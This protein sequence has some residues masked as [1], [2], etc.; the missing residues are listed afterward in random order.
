MARGQAERLMPMIEAVLADRGALFEEL[1]A[2]GVGI[3]PGNFTGLRISVA[4][5]RG[6][7]LSLGV[8]AIGVSGFDLVLGGDAAE[9]T[10]P[11]LV[12]IPV[13]R[14]EHMAYV[15]LYLGLE[16]RGQ[17]TKLQVPLAG[18]ERPTGTS[19]ISD[20]PEDASVLGFEA[21]AIGW[22]TGQNGACRDY[23][24]R[25]LPEDPAPGIAAIAEAKLHLYGS[26]VPRPAPLYIRSADAAPPRDPAPRI[27]S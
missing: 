23:E 13:A 4:T 22:I 27:L 9:V 26:A 21:S 16:P 2:I 17:A 14:E 8:P 11:R 6:L 1:D 10:R 24:R 3:G 5:A 15:R 12:S 19:G 25:D 18:R 20:L 7:A